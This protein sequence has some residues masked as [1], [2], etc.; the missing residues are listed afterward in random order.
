MT[1]IHVLTGLLEPRLWV[2]R[3]QT[4]RLSNLLACDAERRGLDLNGLPVFEARLDPQLHERVHAQLRS[5]EG[6]HS[7]ERDEHCKTLPRTAHHRFPADLWCAEGAAR[8]LTA[9]P[10]ATS[11]TRL[12]VHLATASRYRGGKLIAWSPGRPVE[13]FDAVEDDALGPVFEVP[14]RGLDQHLLLFKF[15]SARGEVEPEYANRLW[16]AQDGGEIWAHS[17]ST[18]IGSRRPRMKS[19]VVR[20][21]EHGE[22]SSTPQMHLW[23]ESSDFAATVRGAR[24]PRGWIRFEHPVYSD[25]PYQFLFFDPGLEPAWEHEEARRNVLLREGGD[26]WTMDGEGRMRLLGRAGIWTLEGDHELFGWEPSRDRPVLIEVAHRAPGCTLAG[27]LVLD[28][29]VNRSRRPLE[30]GL[31]PGPDGRWSFRA[32]PEVVTSFRFR[33]AEGPEPVARH[34]YKVPDV[35]RQ[36]TRL[37]AVLGREDPVPRRPPED[38]FRDPPF[39]IKRAGAWVAD[40]QVR[41][42]LRCPT[43]TTAELIG[44]WTG[45]ESEPFALRSTLDGA[46]WWGQVPLASITSKLDR[47]SIHGALYK[48]VLNQIRLVRDPAGEWVEGD[49]PEKASRLVDRGVECGQAARE[50]AKA[51]AG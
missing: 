39:P 36:T 2:W 22:P 28:V 49:D 51:A 27:Q 3:D 32:F 34:T 10:F 46:F 42:A 26:A 6:W 18:W 8:V 5:G 23:Q 44:E 33:S 48:Y 40:G 31:R 21:L 29:W 47:S 16:C 41:F 7:K 19:L 20:L 17:R 24:E 11:Q 45:W 43:A 50:R 37:F 30:V 4:E 35:G 25:R 14:L 1:R 15:Q 9:N 12:R 38:L 13:V